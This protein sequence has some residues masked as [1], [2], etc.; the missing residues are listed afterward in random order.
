MASDFATLP[1]NRIN[2]PIANF[3]QPPARPVIPTSELAAMLGKTITGAA[4]LLSP[5]ER[6]RKEL[7]LALLGT[8]LRSDAMDQELKS[9]LIQSNRIQLGQQTKDNRAFG[10]RKGVTAP[11]STAGQGDESGSSGPPISPLALRHPTTHPKDYWSGYDL[12]EIPASKQSEMGVQPVKLPTDELP[13]DTTADE[14]KTAIASTD[15]EDS[16]GQL[17]P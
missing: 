11:G 6:R 13:P 17:S 5:E 14:D 1:G 9:Q 10:A 15:D 16:V 12:S 3:V 8:R 4:E 2:Y 7:E